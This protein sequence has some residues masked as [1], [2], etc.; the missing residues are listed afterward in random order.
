MFIYRSYAGQFQ[1]CI[2]ASKLNPPLIVTISEQT[3]FEA[4]LTAY[5]GAWDG[6]RL[7]YYRLLDEFF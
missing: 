1:N 7:S 6:Q 5:R 4:S 2:A 3:G